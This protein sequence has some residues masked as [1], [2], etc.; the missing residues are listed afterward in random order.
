VQE[1]RPNIAEQRSGTAR[2]AAAKTAAAAKGN[3][4][5]RFAMS[6]KEAAAAIAAS[7]AGIVDP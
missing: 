7:I 4:A 6:A 2:A 1:R 3:E 5:P